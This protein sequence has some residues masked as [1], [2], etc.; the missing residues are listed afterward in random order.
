MRRQSDEKKESVYFSLD[1]GL[2]DGPYVQALMTSDKAE[3]DKYGGVAPPHK[4]DQ[5]CRR[6]QTAG[7]FH[8]G[9]FP[10]KPKYKTGEEK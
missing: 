7:Q 3:G 8:L 5:Y 2:P 4:P 10:R 6:W 1:K 9:Y